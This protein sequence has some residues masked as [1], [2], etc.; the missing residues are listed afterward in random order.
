MK[1]QSRAKVEDLYEHR[2]DSGEW[3]D[4]PTQIEVRSPRSAVVSF[5]MPPDEF[6]SLTAAAERTG[7][8]LSQYIRAAIQMRVHGLSVTGLTY[9]FAGATVTTRAGAWSETVRPETRLE[10]FVPT[11]TSAA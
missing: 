11:A 9:A 4:E 7:E 10:G 8:R 3:E 5:R 2:H 1:K 6:E